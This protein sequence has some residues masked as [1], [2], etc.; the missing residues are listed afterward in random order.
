[1]D[2][3]AADAGSGEGAHRVLHPYQGAELP[4]LSRDG[5]SPHQLLQQHRLR[6]RRREHRVLP[7]QL[8][9]QAGSAV[10]L[11]PA[12][13]RQQPGDRVAGPALPRRKCPISSTRPTAGS[14]TPTTGPTRRPAPTARSRKTI[15]A[16]WTATRK[17][18]RRPRDPGTRREEGL[19]PGVAH[20]RGLR[21][22]S[23]GVRAA[24]SAAAQGLGPSPAGESAE[25]QAGRT[26]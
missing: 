16:T 18:A 22:L 11:D 21:Q 19:H 8:H 26:G 24:D 14:R 25:G 12:G 6:R 5:G 1:M 20:R 15:P 17:P 9:P 10:R 2:K 7:G 13:G 4:G 23:A 3:R